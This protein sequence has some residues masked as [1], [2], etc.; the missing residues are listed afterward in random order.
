MGK[1]KKK[2]IGQVLFCY[3]Q[4]KKFIIWKWDSLIEEKILSGTP[5]HYWINDVKS[6]K[7]II[8]IHPAFG[9]YTCFDTQVDYFKD[10][11]VITIDLIG[12]GKSIGKGTIED[13]S[14]YIKGIMEKENI[15]K[16]NLVGISIGAVLVQDFANRYPNLVASLT[17][18]GGYDINN[19]DK[20]L[21]KG[22]SKEQMKM[23]LKAIMKWRK[24]HQL[25]GIK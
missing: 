18:I 10:Y 14:L 11:R 25:C 21:Q 22:N 13:T 20:S 5:I 6:D 9:D 15:S 19:F 2:L 16:I 3:N 4:L 7:S 23:M 24:K 8:F 1:E 17:C 12:H